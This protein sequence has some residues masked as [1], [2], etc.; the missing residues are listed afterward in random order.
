[1][2]TSALALGQVDDER[3]ALVRSSVE[4]RP[5]GQDWYAAAVLPE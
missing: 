2:A 1:M 4:K 3:H 5:A